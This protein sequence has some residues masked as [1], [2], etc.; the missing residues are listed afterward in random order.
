MLTV[1][2]LSGLFLTA[3]LAAT[4]VPFQSEFVFVAQQLAETAELWVLIAI[5]GLGN[6]LG[7]FVNYGLGRGIDRF[8]DRRWFP[9][10]PATLDRAGAWFERYGVWV[11]LFS[12]LPVGDVLTV[13]AGVLRTNIWLFGLL[14]AIG[15]FGRYAALGW[16]TALAQ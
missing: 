3:F 15:K 4:V 11:L 1:T 8:R 2:A 7:A 12:W 13:L 5:A 6:T 9:A 16:A 14:V 10:T